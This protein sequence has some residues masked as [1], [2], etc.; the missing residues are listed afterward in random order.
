[1]LGLHKKLKNVSVEGNPLKSIRR[2]IIAKGSAGILAYLGDRYIEEN[3][4]K[5]EEWA[6]EQN[7]ADKI[8]EKELLAGVEADKAK[9]K[10]EAQR[11]K[12]EKDQEEASNYC[13]IGGV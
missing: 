1:M 5:A 11:K 6:I 10:E 12:Y 8:Q 3:D 4:G 13:V 9:E 2:P 7:K